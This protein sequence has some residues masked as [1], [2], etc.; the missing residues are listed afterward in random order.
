[1]ERLGTVKSGSNTILGSGLTMCI[2]FTDIYIYM[3]VCMYVCM[4]NVKTFFFLEHSFLFFYLPSPSLIIHL[5]VIVKL[6]YD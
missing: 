5:L 1:M 3:Y 6:F 4:K 2:K